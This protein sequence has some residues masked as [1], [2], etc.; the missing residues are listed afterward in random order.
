MQP[1]NYCNIESD[2]LLPPPP[3]GLERLGKLLG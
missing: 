3:M 1:S 2:V